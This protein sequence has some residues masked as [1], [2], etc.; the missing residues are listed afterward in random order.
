MTT[1]CLNPEAAPPEFGRQRNSRRLAGNCPPH[2]I[3]TAAI[4]AAAAQLTWDHWIV[5][6]TAWQR[7][8]DDRSMTTTDRSTVV[9]GSW[10]VWSAGARSDEQVEAVALQGFDIRRSAGRWRGEGAG[11]RNVTVETTTAAHRKSIYNRRHAPPCGRFH[12]YGSLGYVAAGATAGGLAAETENEFGS[13]EARYI[14]PFG[15]F[16]FCSH[17]LPDLP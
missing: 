13:R 14:V 7:G 9:S 3:C 6:F 8:N 10:S 11:W 2:T 12:T 16:F 15:P 1:V 5:N 17:S 4:G